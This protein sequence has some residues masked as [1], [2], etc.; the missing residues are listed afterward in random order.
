MKKTKKIFILLILSFIFP[1]LLAGNEIHSTRVSFLLGKGEIIRKGKSISLEL[2]AA[3]HDGNIIRI[4]K[5]G[6]A[7][8]S[9]SGRTTLRIKGPTIFRFNI[10]NVKRSIEKAQQFTLMIKLLNKNNR[11]ILPRTVVVSV[12]TGEGKRQNRKLRIQLREAIEL[13]E[14]GDL[15]SSWELLTSLEKTPMLRVSAR[16]YIHFYKGEV[17]YAKNRYAEALAIF[18]SLNEKKFAMREESYLRAVMSAHLA[19]KTA[20]MKTIISEYESDYSQ[21]GSY[22]DFMK[23]MKE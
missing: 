10:K 11:Y 8:L 19:G 16:H 2:H 12:R 9:V 14:E 13:L 15:D 20:A 17:L 23:T 6:L 7:A 5:K 1:L 3:I 21:N 4:N 18:R 22:T